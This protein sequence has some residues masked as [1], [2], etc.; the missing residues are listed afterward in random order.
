M[1]DTPVM[2]ITGAR[3]GIGRHMVEYYLEKG[4]RLIGCSRGESDYARS[5]YEHFCLDVCDESAVAKMFTSIR[6][7]Y[8][9]LDVLINNAGIAS[10]NHAL[11]T[12]TATVRRLVETNLVGAFTM[13][14]EA[15]KLMQRRRFG[16]IINFSTAAVALRLEGEAVYAASKAAL[17]MLTK[18][19]A[20]E[21]ADFGITVNVVA[22]TI[23]D[24]DLV[25]GVPSD[26]IDAVIQRQAIRR[27]G[28]FRD[29][30]NV[31]DFF[32]QRSSDFISGQTIYLGGV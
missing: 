16:R 17:E 22:P 11:L 15:A 8:G 13:C 10:M 4:F 31:T 7:T 27:K 12:P 3:K 2:L 21:F 9:R 24:T 25:R 28:E 29:V 26:R 20:K 14:R 6:R 19:L 30:V 1:D 18:V 23:T 5:G 32:I